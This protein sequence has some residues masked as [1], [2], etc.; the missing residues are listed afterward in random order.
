METGRCLPSGCICR[1]KP[2]R[3]SLI[4]QL[5][6]FTGAPKGSSFFP[7]YG[8]KKQAPFLAA[9]PTVLGDPLANKTV[10]RPAA[11]L[12]TGHHRLDSRSL[13]APSPRPNRGA[14]QPAPLPDKP[15]PS[16]QDPAAAPAR[17]RHSLSQPVIS[18]TQAVALREPSFPLPSSTPRRPSPGC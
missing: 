16:P 8:N 3:S 9:A 18:S 1:D 2:G 4:K 12:S 11:P 5:L 10:R 17:P 13:H 15:W 7:Y 6:R 14:P